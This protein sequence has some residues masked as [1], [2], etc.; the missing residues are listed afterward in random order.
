[1]TILRLRSAVQEHRQQLHARIAGMRAA[2]REVSGSTYICT[3]QYKN[4]DQSIC[5]ARN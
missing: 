2:V 5:T 1:M 3:D 4:H